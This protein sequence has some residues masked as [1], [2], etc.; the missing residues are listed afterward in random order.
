MPGKEENGQ[1]DSRL[2]IVL[3]LTGGIGEGNGRE[4]TWC[5]LRVLSM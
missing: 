1:L 4:G 5:I 2:S 3:A